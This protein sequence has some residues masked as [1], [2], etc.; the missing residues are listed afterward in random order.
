MAR[1]QMLVE[2]TPGPVFSEDV[3]ILLFAGKA[4]EYEDPSTFSPLARAGIWDDSVLAE[5]FASGY[6]DLVLLEYDITGIDSGLRWTD[7]LFQSLK[8]NYTL[9]YRD[10]LYS[11]VP[12]R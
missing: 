11:Y 8:E 5:K 10:W 9:L 1:I 6:F 7:R 2:S 3:S 12:R 4:F